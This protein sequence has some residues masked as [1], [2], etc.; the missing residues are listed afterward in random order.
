MT[1]AIRI[2]AIAVLTFFLA[3]YCATIATAAAL[4][5]APAAQAA[6]SDPDWMTLARPIYDAFAKHEY[7]LMLALTVILLV[8]LAKRW[9]HY[10]WMSTDMAGSASALV[11]AAA[12]ATAAGLVAPGAPTWPSL[13]LLRS[14]LMVGLTA[15]GG[16]AVIKN[17]LVD[18]ILRPLAAKAPAWL[19]P[20]FT[21]VFFAFDKVTHT[22]S[23]AIIATAEKAGQTAVESTP[24]PG[25]VAI[26][27]TPQEVK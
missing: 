14:A 21:I 25:P 3:F 4:Q 12:T 17:L 16:Y 7:G 13:D 11:V 2:G 22:D 8:A 20:I 24:A 10:A 27:G 26:V 9:L 23:A 18:P 5:V 19:Q 6:T 15:A 1:R